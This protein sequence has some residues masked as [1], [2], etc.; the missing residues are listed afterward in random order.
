LSVRSGLPQR[1]H[2]GPDP[3]NS[4]GGFQSTTGPT[5]EAASSARDPAGETGDAAA[6]H[7]CSVVFRLGQAAQ[8]L[9]L[10][11]VIPL[12]TI[13]NPVRKSCF[14]GRSSQNGRTVA[15]GIQR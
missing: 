15:L 10:D 1:P 11:A 5:I 8:S 7:D 13:S 4:E 2:G 12:S 3:E 14:V 9:D 6:P